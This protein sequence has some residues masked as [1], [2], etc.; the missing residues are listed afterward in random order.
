MAGPAVDREF[1]A[2][3]VRPNPKTGKRD[4]TAMYGTRIR[5]RVKD[6]PGLRDLFVVLQEAKTW[7]AQSPDRRTPG[8][9]RRSPRRCHL[10][11]ELHRHPLAATQ[12]GDPSTIERVEQRVRRHI[13]PRLGAQPLSGIPEV[14]SRWKKRLRKD[15]GPGLYPSGLGGFSQRPPARDRKPPPRTRPMP[16]QYGRPPAPGPRP[17]PGRDLAARTG[18]GGAEGPA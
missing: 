9:V 14:L 18:P 10:P 7:L 15:L 11:R 3:R 4:L 16:F 8:R 13:V 6:M 5:C 17:R 12:G 2:R 1:H